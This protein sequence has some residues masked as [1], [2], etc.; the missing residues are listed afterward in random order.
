MKKSK[1]PL[2]CKPP[3]DWMNLIENNIEHVCNNCNNEISH[4]YWFIC[5]ECLN[6][7][8][9]KSCRAIGK[10]IH[11]HNLKKVL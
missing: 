5:D 9:C 4:E 11:E 10:S 8:F 7:K 2:G 1:V 6:M 3:E